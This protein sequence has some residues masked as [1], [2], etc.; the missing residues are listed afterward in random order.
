MKQSE[1]YRQMQ[2]IKPEGED[3]YQFLKA[4]N[5]LDEFYENTLDRKDFLKKLKRDRN[6]D[7]ESPIWYAF[8]WSYDYGVNWE[9]LCNKHD[10]QIRSKQ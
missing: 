7:D 1:F 5:V 10:K 3:F 4:H 8:P 2:A 6:M 9:E